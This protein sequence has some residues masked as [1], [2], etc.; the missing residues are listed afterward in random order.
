MLL[1]LLSRSLLCQRHLPSPPHYLAGVQRCDVARVAAACASVTHPRSDV[2][3]A[4][5]V[6]AEL[7]YV[8][9][10]CLAVGALVSSPLAIVRARLMLA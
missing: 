5:S 10:A 6:D 8:G 4:P 2:V 7:P 1:A 3:G 9:A